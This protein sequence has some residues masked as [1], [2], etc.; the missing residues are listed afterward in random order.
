MADKLSF[1]CSCDN[2]NIE[3]TFSELRK[4]LSEVHKI[5]FTVDGMAGSDKQMISHVAANNRFSSV[6]L[7]KMPTGLEFKEFYIVS[8]TKEFKV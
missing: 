2:Y 8:R 5:P 3:M 4:H 6:Y 7:W 1:K